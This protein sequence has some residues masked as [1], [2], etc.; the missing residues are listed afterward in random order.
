MSSDDKGKI[1]FH[2]KDP[3]NHSVQTRLDRREGLFYFNA[4]KKG[5]YSFIFS[6]EKVS[7]FW[8]FA[9]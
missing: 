6:N 7:L 8:S 3:K 4:T 1:D 9:H 5:V 2:V